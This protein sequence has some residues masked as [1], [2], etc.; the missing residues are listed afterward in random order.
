MYPIGPDLYQRNYDLEKEIDLLSYQDFNVTNRFPGTLG[1]FMDSLFEL[2]QSFKET[3]SELDRENIE[4][5]LYKRAE[6]IPYVNDLFYRKFNSSLS[7]EQFNY[8][9]DLLSYIDRLRNLF[10]TK[11]KH[12]FDVIG[13]LKKECSRQLN[14]NE[15]L[16][17]ILFFAE[18]YIKE[19][20]MR[21]YYTET[22]NGIGYIGFHE[23]QLEIMIIPDWHEVK[24][25]N[26]HYHKILLTK[27]DLT[28]ITNHFL[29]INKVVEINKINS[30]GV[31]ETISNM[32]E[33]Y[34][35][36]NILSRIKRQIENITKES[37]RKET[38]KQLIDFTLFDLRR[39]EE[40]S[41]YS[42]SNSLNEEIRTLMDSAKKYLDRALDIIGYSE[43][44]NLIKSQIVLIKLKIIDVIRDC[45]NED[46]LRH[47]IEYSLG[48]FKVNNALY[49]IS[50]SGKTKDE[51]ICFGEENLSS[52]M[53]SN[54]TCLFNDN[55]IMVD[56]E[57]RVGVGRTDIRIKRGRTCLGIVECK[58]IK[59]STDVAKKTR[60]GI[61][62]LYGRYSENMS[63][64]FGRETELYL[65]IFTYDKNFLSIEKSIKKAID[66]YKESNSLTMNLLKR[67]HNSIQFEYLP[68]EIGELFSPKRKVITLYVCNLEINYS[69]KTAEA[70]KI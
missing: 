32:S 15:G 22:K 68:K 37:E 4:K 50:G 24:S 61:H 57:S 65:I 6:S 16:E 52:I 20:R 49:I 39:V 51:G 7:N 45:K 46:N 40:L 54:I 26:S 66:Q 59:G 9:K 17:K 23:I 55:R 70:I 33:A 58:L 10:R 67:S 60:E 13:F 63:L 47:Y 27:S 29:K 48:E 1:L 19:C 2:L 43:G 44:L 12:L 41:Y 34:S 18:N 56:C 14:E 35:L 28:D 36:N 38:L 42:M 5:F 11:S 31:V 62:Q 8:L 30:D 25:D 21:G 3:G 53:A 69:K 64:N